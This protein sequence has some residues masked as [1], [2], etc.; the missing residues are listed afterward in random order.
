MQVIKE[1]SGV[2]VTINE[3]DLNKKGVIYL[4]EFPNGKAYVGQSSKSLRKRIQGHC[5]K[6]SGCPLVKKAMNK[7]GEVL[8]RLKSGVPGYRG[9]LAGILFTYE[10]SS[11]K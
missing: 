8:R 11:T 5:D 3:E 1:Y 10:S 9:K 2:K 4:M 6:A 7:Y